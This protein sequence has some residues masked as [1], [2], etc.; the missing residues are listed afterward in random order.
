MKILIYCS[1]SINE[2][3]DLFNQSNSI[4]YEYPFILH[5]K[6]IYFELICQETFNFNILYYDDYK[7]IYHIINLIIFILLK[8]QNL[9]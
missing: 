4:L 9:N 8:I 6:N 2:I 1:N 7:L 5:L 3:N